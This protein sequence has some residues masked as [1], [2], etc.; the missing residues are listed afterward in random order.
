[1]SDTIQEQTANITSEEDR[2]AK[3]DAAKT[4]MTSTLMA[5][6]VGSALFMLCMN[7]YSF[8]E[9]VVIPILMF[10]GCGIFSFFMLSL[11]LLLSSCSVGVIIGL[12]VW[13]IAKKVNDSKRM[14]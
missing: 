8:V 6:M 11:I 12:L 14:C 5:V 13:Y 7:S 1:M 9:T 4:V 2:L 3:I 10:F